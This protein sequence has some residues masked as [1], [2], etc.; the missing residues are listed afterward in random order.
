MLL[1]FKVTMESVAIKNTRIR[2]PIIDAHSWKFYQGDLWPYTI[3]N[4]LPAVPLEFAQGCS[5]QANS[6]S[7]LSLS[8]LA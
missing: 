6:L 2:T 8:Y 3:Q 1:I 5:F 7:M 4:I